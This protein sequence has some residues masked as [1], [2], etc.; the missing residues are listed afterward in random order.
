[1]LLHQYM[2][3]VR[4][5]LNKNPFNEF[6]LL[7]N[8]GEPMKAEDITKHVKRTFKGKFEGRKVNVMTIRQSVIA[9]LLKS[10]NDLRIVQVFAGHKYPSTTE[11]YKQTNLESLHTAITQHHPIR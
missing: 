10:G 2:T 3:E 5:K 4:P 8:R 9:N 6:L 11:K 1:M 7:G